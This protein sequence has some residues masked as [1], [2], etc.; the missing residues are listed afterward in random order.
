MQKHH[1]AWQSHL[2]VFEEAPASSCSLSTT[3][4]S[5]DKPH[6]P[7]RRQRQRGVCAVDAAQSQKGNCAVC[8]NMVG[9]EALR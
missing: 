6:G 7:H 5:Q 1:L 9:T 4:N 8:S 2:R 3:H